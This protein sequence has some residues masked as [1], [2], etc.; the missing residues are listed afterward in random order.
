MVI[1]RFNINFC[2]HS[3]DHVTKVTIKCSN[4]NPS[5]GY[6]T[7]YFFSLFALQRTPITFV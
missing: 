4:F 5:Y 1:G 3:T 6:N 2:N 7:L